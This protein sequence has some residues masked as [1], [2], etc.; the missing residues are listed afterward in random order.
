MPYP[1][2][3]SVTIGPTARVGTDAVAAVPLACAAAAPAACAG[4]LTLAAV[5]AGGAPGTALGAEVGAPGAELGTA[6]FVLLPGQRLRIDV[7]LARTATALVQ[8][9][10]GQR[11]RVRA[12]VAALGAYALPSA[13]TLI[14]PQS[15]YENPLR[16]VHDLDPWRIDE[17]VD[18][19]GD[20]PVM[21]IGPGIVTEASTRSRFFGLQG[22]NNVVYRLT[23]GSLAG[24]FIYVGEACTPAVHV[25]ERVTSQTEICTLT[26][27]EAYPGAEIGLYAGPHDQSFPLAAILG[28]YT[29]DGFPDGTETGCG[30]AMSQLLA[31]LG[32]PGGNTTV[33]HQHVPPY[34]STNLSTIVGSPAACLRARRR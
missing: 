17:G 32:A 5:P 6:G 22:A 10:P 18:Y 9:A 4:A 15:P 33:A 24:H 29:G 19:H 12:T 26:G 31:T 21:A 25:G 30:V 1:L 2:A 13:I 14:G 3:V 11:L 8:G 23:A 27:D 16:G 7:R 34:V 28:T 20:G